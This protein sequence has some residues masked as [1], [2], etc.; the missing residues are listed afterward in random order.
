M[1]TKDDLLE[2]IELIHHL[3]GAMFQFPAT[4]P[5]TAEDDANTFTP[6]TRSNHLFALM[7][8]DNDGKADYIDFKRTVLSDAE[9]IQ[10]FLVYDG[11]I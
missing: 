7:D 8:E 5:E 1:I 4:V 11:V 9:I 6:Q 10:G 2:S 3:M